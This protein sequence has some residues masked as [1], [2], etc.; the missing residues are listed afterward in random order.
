MWFKN[1]YVCNISVS[2]QGGDLGLLW[3][4]KGDMFKGKPRPKHVLLSVAGINV[5]IDIDRKQRARESSLEV[6]QYI[7]SSGRD[8]HGLHWCN[9]GVIRMAEI[10]AR[11]GSLT[12]S[13]L[14]RA[15]M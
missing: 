3:D 9:W 6:T 15:T 7:C 12:Q 10:K 1:I 2:V 13:D 14:C 5:V 8:R 11:A 4:C